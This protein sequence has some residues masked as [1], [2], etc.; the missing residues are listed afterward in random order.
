[1]NM[2]A[3]DVVKAH[4]WSREANEHY[5]EP[6]WVSARLF[7]VEKFE[8]GVFD[9]AC[10]FGRIVASARAAGLTAIGADIVDRGWSDGLVGD[11]LDME[12][13]GLPQM[14]PNIVTNPPFNIAPQFVQHAL[15]LAVHKVAVVFPIARLNAAHW[16]RCLP[17]YRI[18]L[19]TPRP[20]MPPGHTITAGKKPGGGKVDFCWLV[21]LRGYEG[22]PQVGWIRR[23]A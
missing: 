7:A 4:K 13:G 1:M 2:L 15:E 3:R 16:I 21:F 18:W 20:S 6:E 11:F 19:L 17:L 12:P 8:G 10:G 9:P 23:D 14:P 5:V 22:A